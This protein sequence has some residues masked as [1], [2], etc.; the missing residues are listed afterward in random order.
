MNIISK[1]TVR[2]MKKNKRR[3]FVTIIGVIISVAM[4][5]AVTTI[6]IS[7]L[8]MFKRTVINQEGAWEAQY[9]NV[10]LEK[11]NIIMEHKRVKDVALINKQGFAKIEDIGLD[12][13]LN[14]TYI[15]V[16]A[17]DD[18]A[19]HMYSVK[20]IEGRQPITS[21]EIAIPEK[22]T[23]LKNEGKISVGD[24]VTLQLG[25]RQ[26]FDED[27][28]VLHDVVLTT[29]DDSLN[30]LKLNGM[31]EELVDVNSHTYTVVGL[32]KD[33]VWEVGWGAS[34]VAITA[35]DNDLLSASSTI[36]YV[37][38]TFTDR[39]RA[40][41]DHMKDIGKQ[42]DF[43]YNTHHS[44]LRYD[45]LSSTDSLQSTIYSL[46]GI[47]MFIVI[48]GSISL[49][50]NAFGI[51]VA[52]RS[53]YLGM[54]SS[55]GATKR[56][57]RNSVLVEA[58][59]ISLFSIPLGLLGGWLGIKITFNVISNIMENLS[60][61]N[62]DV[63]LKAVVTPL[64]IVL[65]IIIS[66]ITIFISSWLPA[67]RAS[68]ITAIDAI[69]MSHD[70]KITKR[71]VKNNPLVRKLFGL[72]ADIALKNLKRNKRRY[73]ITVFSLVISIM[74]FISASYFTSMLQKANS[75]S[76][77]SINY[78]LYVN[79]YNREQEEI[80]YSSIIN[81]PDVEDYAIV[82]IQH[83][84][85]VVPAAHLTDGVKEHIEAGIL[86]EQQDGSYEYQ[87]YL[88]S[89]D[90]KSFN[91]FIEK[92]QLQTIDWE[93][94]EQ[95]RAVLL[96]R[97]IYSSLLEKRKIEDVVLNNPLQLQLPISM[98]DRTEKTQEAMD[99]AENWQ[100]KTEYVEIAAAVDEAPFGIDSP[101]S[102]RVLHIVMPHSQ[103]E[104][105]N[106]RYNQDVV[107]HFVYIKTKKPDVVE[108][109][110]L[111]QD[112][113]GVNVSV[114]NVNEQRKQT[115]GIIVILNIFTYG[116]IALIT[117]ISLANIMNTIS[118][119]LQLRKREFAMLRS[120]GMTEKG[121]Y[122][123]INY[124]SIFYG[125]KALLYGIPLSIGL[126]YLMYKGMM[127]SMDFSFELPLLH[128]GIAILGIFIIVTFVMYY[129]GSKI[130]K[131][132]IVE[133]IKQENL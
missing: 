22:L 123:M 76:G 71:Q 16:Y 41:F 44:L 45:L 68:R 33:T 2:H 131:G 5:M 125:L 93:S 67:K 55:V 39:T 35:L 104:N 51:S 8:D 80:D 113:G 128:Y 6:G 13:K 18:V 54:L 60:I 133:A 29:G 87:V 124:E 27:G 49:I 62:I 11:L 114:W 37:G 66:L 23:T 50:Y 70:I 36:D 86:E 83:P 82:H 85:A 61:L 73:Q 17:L 108:E 97:I 89:L 126:N 52:D 75:M 28:Q 107:N 34:H 90:D 119:G 4:I 110:V 121:F 91:A 14:K 105:L 63:A 3:T 38:T 40:I 56:Q 42:G 118:T 24:Q 111:E 72:E 58:A 98:I 43:N 96:N 109:H 57:K 115:E 102:L 69:R 94:E 129:A 78:D 59:I 46:V 30:R 32:I 88:Y 122:R 79:L 47:I 25:T 74:L 26:A 21:N 19:Q 116:F 95:L 92:N 130:K 106:K 65:S 101:S 1:L 132:S 112:F 120:M 10:E 31:Y 81:H 84:S 53:K 127:Q 100:Y 99:E 48:V 117:F 20:L 103:F 64:S 12:S 9:N 7:F 15:E 77:D